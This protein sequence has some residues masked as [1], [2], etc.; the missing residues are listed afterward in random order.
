MSSRGF[1]LI[2]ISIALALLGLIGVGLGGVI[3]SLNQ[4]ASA[5]AREQ[6]L[7]A[8]GNRIFTHIGLWASR[9]GYY[10]TA[11]LR[12]RRPQD[13][14]G[15]I[16]RDLP[17]DN[18]EFCFLDKN[19]QRLHRFRVQARRLQQNIAI[20]NNCNGTNMWTNLTDAIINDIAF[21]IPPHNPRLLDIRL[22]IG[23][24]GE[25]VIM[26]TRLPLHSLT[27]VNIP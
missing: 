4:G 18:I 3:I 19:L 8:E 22:D 14:T 25:S 6:A 12:F 27:F 7:L 24:S 1:S 5:M 13:D 9:A 23:Y 16:L 21:T 17:R 11:S 20:N 2:E 10:Q 15:N 26:R